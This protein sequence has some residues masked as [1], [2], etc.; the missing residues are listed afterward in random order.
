MG[1]SQRNKGANA[2]RELANYIKDM[3]GYQVR[4]GQVFNHEP[5]IVGLKGIHIECKRHETLQLKAWLEQS[6]TWAE[7]HDDGIPI[8]VYRQSRQPWKVYMRLNDLVEMTGG[9]PDYSDDSTI[10]MH[11]VEFM[12]VY[13]G[14][15]DDG[16]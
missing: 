12:D 11:L 1:A 10:Q 3:W 13:R 7:K 9:F 8:V 14:W 16:M 15:L 4:R 5:D 6:I 2:E